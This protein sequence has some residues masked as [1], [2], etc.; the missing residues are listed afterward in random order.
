MIKELTLKFGR[1]AGTPEQKIP[2]TPITVFVGPNNSGKSKILTEIEQF[3]R[4]GQENASCLIL[5][6]L[7]FIGF[8]R[9]VIPDI[10]ERIRQTPSPGEMV[11]VDHIIVGSR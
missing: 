4:S 1:S 3:C 6:A 10:I 9:E 2:V 11:P 8:E 5:K 7:E